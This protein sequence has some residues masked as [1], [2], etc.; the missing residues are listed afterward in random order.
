M[1]DIDSE[2]DIYDNV[3]SEIKKKTT[4]IRY[5]INKANQEFLVDK[6]MPRSLEEVLEEKEE[7]RID[8]IINNRKYFHKEILKK[9]GEI[10]RD[11]SIPHIIFYGGRGTGKKTLINLFLEL[12]FDKS[13]YKMDD[14]KY[15]VKGSG[16]NEN[17][18]SVKQSD[19]HIII[20]PTNTNFDR[21]LIQDIVKEYA[22]KY[23]LCV[24]DKNRNFKMVQINNL[25]NLSYYAQTSLRRT[26]E[27]YSRT[28]RFISWCYSLSKVIEP[29]RSRCLC[30]HVP[31]IKREELV[32]WIYMISMNERIGY[33]MRV[34]E[35]I[36]DK[37]GGNIKEILWRVEL[38]KKF[39]KI[40]NEYHRL[41]KM[42]IKEIRKSIIDEISMRCIRE[43][44]N[45]I[46]KYKKK[47]S[48]RE[49]DKMTIEEMPKVIKE[50]IEEYENKYGDKE[51]RIRENMMKEIKY[52]NNGILSE[53][54]VQ[55]KREYIYKI[56]ITN[57]LH[58]TII[59]DLLNNILMIYSN[60]EEE[61]ILEIV[62][63]ANKYDYRLSKCRRERIHIE[64]FIESV[65]QIIIN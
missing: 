16:N 39:G 44:K 33:N 32:E 11:D 17:I 51:K 30:V 34:M 21:Y 12:I 42:L 35:E 65:I 43:L 46:Y 22:K 45:E 13:I 38:Y 54:N 10:S 58:N 56:L 52:H 5:I 3:D 2:E 8:N 60:I 36:I 25:D 48:I 26:M 7:T 19:H 15:S 31:S 63:S 50:K 18:V 41:L 6:Y 62:R 27:K 57:I 37:S 61:K 55:M 23:P 29:L 20:E 14:S 53:G 28:C 1:S 59:K 24:F 49:I 4:N 64:C 47:L 40:D 9:L